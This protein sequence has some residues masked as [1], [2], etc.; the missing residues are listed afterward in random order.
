MT[1][2]TGRQGA[3]DMS[4]PTIGR[5]LVAYS[6]KMGCTAESMAG[7]RH[8]ASS[9]DWWYSPITAT[10]AHDVICCASG[11]TC[12]LSSLSM[13]RR[14][15]GAGAGLSWVGFVKVWPWKQGALAVSGSTY[16]CE[17]AK[18]NRRIVERILT[19]GVLEGRLEVFDELCDPGVINHAAAPQAGEG[20]DALKRVIGFSRTAMPD[21]RWIDRS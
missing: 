15:Q 16:G 10:G 9:F 14:H 13:G 4:T 7:D 5:V 19:E 11:W 1:T 3:G 17:I 2:V 20:I 8:S 6:S 12:W 21:Q 18:R